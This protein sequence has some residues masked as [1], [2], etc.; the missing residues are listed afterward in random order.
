[1]NI[2]EQNAPESVG[3]SIEETAR[4]LFGDINPD[5]ESGTRTEEVTPAAETPVVEEPV[6][7][8][9]EPV[10]QERLMQ[11]PEA[12]PTFSP[13][14]LAQFEV[15]QQSQLGQQV[16]KQDL[17]SVQQ[18]IQATAPLPDEEVAKLTNRFT[19]T[20][21]E[22]DAIYEAENKADAIKAFNDV[23][24]RTVVQAVTMANYL[25]QDH[26]GK[27]METARPYMQFA[28]EQRNMVRQEMFYAAHPDLRGADVVVQAVVS[29]MIQQGIRFPDEKTTFDAIAQASKAQLAKLG[30]QGQ[31]AVPANGKVKQP[32]ASLPTGSQGGTRMA[33][34][35]SGPSNTAKNLFG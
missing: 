25:A 21:K 14:Q 5:I 34:V 12:L 13:E 18:R 9:P 17:A 6:V 26:A 10:V 30:K 11:Q 28:E 31:G 7:V 27:V 8:Q 15:W 2:E 24:Q 35:G 1:M 3:Q 32:M 22:F 16:L 23:L 33:Q 20:E 4:S 19:M 29:N